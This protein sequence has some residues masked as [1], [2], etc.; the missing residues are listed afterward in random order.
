LL[1]HDADH[2]AVEQITSSFRLGVPLYTAAF[3]LAFVN[4]TA[5]LLLNLVMAVFFA[6]A[7][8]T[9]GEAPA[10]TWRLLKK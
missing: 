9:L 3:G 1:R 7:E 5:S 8:T 10:I 4:V 6:L 2:H